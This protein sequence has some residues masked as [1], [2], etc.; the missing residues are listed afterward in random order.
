M[1]A[2]TRL[3]VKIMHIR[4][5][6]QIT[7]G[8]AVICALFVALG[9]ISFLGV[10]QMISKA[11]ESMLAA[12]AVAEMKEMEIAHLKWAATVEETLLQEFH[13]GMKVTVEKDDHKCGFG[14]WLYGEGRR[15]FDR[16]FPELAATVKAFEKPHFALHNSINAINENLLEAEDLEGAKDD[17]REETQP[18]LHIL[19]DN[20][21]KLVHKLGEIEESGDL[22]AKETASRVRSLVLVFS[23]LGVVIALIVTFWVRWVFRREVGGEV[24]DM[25]EILQR[26]AGGDLTVE[27]DTRKALPGSMLIS[28]SEVKS[29]LTGI[30]GDI[31]GSVENLTVA[32]NELSGLAGRVGE[33]AANTSEKSNTVAAAAEEMSVNMN[34]VASATGG[35]AENINMVAAATEEMTSTVGEIAENT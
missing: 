20:F 27:I 1:Q 29:G 22:A 7:I 15:Q 25:R 5:S 6:R 33:A 35:T 4:L 3:I 23:I 8:L 24:E 13:S 31:H 34:S 19:L 26:I 28:L 30:A 32:S 11:D 17:F 10:Q 9:V 14:K 21:H 16:N 18:A 12:D 2:L